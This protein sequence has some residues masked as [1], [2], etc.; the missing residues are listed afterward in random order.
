MSVSI[1]R[2]LVQASHFACFYRL[3]FQNLRALRKL[4]ISHFEELVFLTINRSVITLQGGFPHTSISKLIHHPIS[5]R[6]GSKTIQALTDRSGLIIAA[7]KRTTIRVVI[8]FKISW[9]R[10]EQIP[11]RS[12]K[13]RQ[14]LDVSRHIYKQSRY[15]RIIIQRISEVC[16]THVFKVAVIENIV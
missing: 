14:L 8:A 5:C 12:I 15:N 6:V 4:H 13:P 11:A 16:L 2:A 10:P 9:L 7:A 3:C 1:A